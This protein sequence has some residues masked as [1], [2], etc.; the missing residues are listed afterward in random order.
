M[1]SKL[2]CGL[3]ASLPVFAGTDFE[4]VRIVV[5]CYHNSFSHISSLSC[6]FLRRKCS[7]TFAPVNAYAEQLYGPSFNADLMVWRLC[8]DPCSSVLLLFL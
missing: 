6:S 2:E 1:N 7:Y 8:L 3:F 4:S 5:I